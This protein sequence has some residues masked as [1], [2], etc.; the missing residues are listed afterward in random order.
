MHRLLGILVILIMLCLADQAMA[1]WRNYASN[2]YHTS[3][4]SSQGIDE[5]KAISIAQQHFKGRVLAINHSGN[6]Y[7]VKILNSQGIIHIILIDAANGTI[8]PSR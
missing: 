1:D 5:Q 8:I 2:Y 7:R 6:I 3:N 4:S